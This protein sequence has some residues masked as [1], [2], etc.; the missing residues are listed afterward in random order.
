MPMLPVPI[1]PTV[2]RLL[3]A[4][5]SSRPRAEAGMMVG[6][7][8][9]VAV[10]RKRRRVKLE[11]RGMRRASEKFGASTQEPLAASCYFGAFSSLMRTLRYSM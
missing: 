4:G 5:L 1:T 7:P 11:V 10:W 2:M 3:A 9:A 6:T 8:R